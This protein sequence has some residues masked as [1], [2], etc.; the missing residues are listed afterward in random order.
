MFSDKQI[1]LSMLGTQFKIGHK[2]TGQLYCGVLDWGSD[3]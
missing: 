3:I 2:E 1:V